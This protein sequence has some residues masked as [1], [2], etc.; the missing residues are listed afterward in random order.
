MVRHKPDI[1][2]KDTAISYVLLRIQPDLREPNAKVWRSILKAILSQHIMIPEVY[3]TMDKV[4][5]I[6]IVNHSREIRDMARS[7]YFQF[8]MEYDQ[9]RGRLEKQ[10]K[11]LLNNLTYPTQDGRL[12]VMELLHLIILKAGPRLLRACLI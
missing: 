4:S 11:F 8:L 1:R 3:D 12:S 9:G 10:F 7:A 5:T 6:M 2:L